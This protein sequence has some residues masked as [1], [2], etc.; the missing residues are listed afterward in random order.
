MRSWWLGLSLA[1]LLLV[2]AVA[3]ADAG[4][5]SRQSRILG[6]GVQLVVDG[7]YAEAEPLLLKTISMDP[8]QP[9][10]HY[11]LAIVYKYTGRQADAVKQY[12]IAL[13][14]YSGS[15]IPNLTKCLYGIALVQEDRNDPA[16]AAQAWNDYIRFARRYPSEG[17]AVRIAE[18]HEQQAIMAERARKPSPF[19]PERA[20]RPT[21]R[22]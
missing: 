14:Q 22:E 21:H 12:R 13:S 6:R 15:D 1:G 8:K 20:T 11:N 5:F 17:P 10:A 18:R 7:K 2:P 9:E 16:L 3:H 4:V 19:G